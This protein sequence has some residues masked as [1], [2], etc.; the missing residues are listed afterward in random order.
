[1]LAEQR[2][3]SR[4]ASGL[5]IRNIHGIHRASQKKMQSPNREV[6]GRAA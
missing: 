5:R 1:M 3:A 6:R 4:T 2:I